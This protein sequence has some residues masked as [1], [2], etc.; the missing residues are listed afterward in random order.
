MLRDENGML[1][2]YVY[3]DVNGRDPGSYVTEAA[4]LVRDRVPLPAGYSL[5]W[6]G[7]YEAME[8]VRGRL[9]EVVPLVLALVFALLYLN[10][11]S[12]ART[13]LILLA[14]PFSCV[15]ACWLLWA[16]GY[17]LSVG[18]W[19]GMIA[20]MGVDAETG[21]FMVLYID[22]AVEEWRQ[23]GRLTSR[24]EL[25]EAIVYGAARRIR[26][27]FMTVATMF[28]GLVPILFATGAGSDVM[29]RIAAPMAGGIFTSF[30][31]ELIVYPPLYE[32]WLGRKMEWQ[33]GGTLHSPRSASSGITE[34]VLGAGQ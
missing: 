23:R 31:L 5:A 7:Q 11:R 22:L 9:R 8:R 17:N 20:L 15:G 12:A 2:G 13:M 30:L 3:I 6:S 1:D 33:A 14:V 4:R 10:T 29:K 25:R 21:M 28:L 32:L 34:A 18:V 26:P 19:V 24:G 16:L 27:K